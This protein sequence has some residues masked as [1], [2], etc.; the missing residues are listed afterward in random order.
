MWVFVAGLDKPV[1]TLLERVG[2][3]R[4]DPTRAGQLRG[5]QASRVAVLPRAELLAR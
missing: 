2:D 5:C 1:L 4:R 3:E